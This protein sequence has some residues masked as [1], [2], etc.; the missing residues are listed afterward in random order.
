L[1]KIFDARPRREEGDRDL[2]RV[3]QTSAYQLGQGALDVIRWL[4]DNVYFWPA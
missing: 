2:A 3:A 1:V 4:W